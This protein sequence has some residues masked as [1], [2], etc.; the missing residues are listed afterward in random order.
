MR[1]SIR[2]GC[3]EVLRVNYGPGFNLTIISGSIPE[4][5]IDNWC[6]PNLCA[7]AK[8]SLPVGLT[9]ALGSYCVGIVPAALLVFWVSSLLAVE[10]YAARFRIQERASY[11][12]LSQLEDR[13]KFCYKQ[14]PVCKDFCPLSSK[15]Q[16]LSISNFSFS[17]PTST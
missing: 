12:G 2:E 7:H 16:R 17:M 3:R 10:R 1:L 5:L 15:L 8:Y 9:L 6:S 13:S 11:R 4:T 14:H